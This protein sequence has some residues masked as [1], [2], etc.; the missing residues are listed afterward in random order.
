M[1]LPAAEPRHDGPIEA[2]DLITYDD[3]T[4]I[5]N[6]SVRWLADQVHTGRLRGS[7]KHLSRTE[8]EEV[9]V[10]DW[11]PDRH[12]P[13]GYWCTTSEVCEILG[14]NR[15]RVAQLDAA[16]KL[17][18]YRNA[19]RWASWPT[20]L[21]PTL[22]RVLRNLALGRPC[23][24]SPAGLLGPPVP[25]RIAHHSGSPTCSHTMSGHWLPN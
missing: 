21:P 19:E 7:T 23:I 3:A 4:Q 6:R 24:S 12:I 18:G 25:I 11:R 2:W 16:G 5:V 17:R 13:G 10:Q 20:D 1:P 8:V 15:Q 22:C 14:V 9:A